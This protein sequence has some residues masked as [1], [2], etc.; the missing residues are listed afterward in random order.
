MDDVFK[1]LKSLTPEEWSKI[2]KEMSHTPDC[3]TIMVGGCGTLLN[4]P[5]NHQKW[6]CSTTCPLKDK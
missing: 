1:R 2:I 6:I 5:N 3:Y 4:P